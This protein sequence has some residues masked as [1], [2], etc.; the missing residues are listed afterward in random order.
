M[1]GSHMEC[2]PRITRD[3]HDRSRPAQLGMSAVSSNFWTVLLAGA[4]ELRIAPPR[5]REL[6]R[7]IAALQVR[8]R[9]G[10]ANK[11]GTRHGACSTRRARG[12]TPARP[13]P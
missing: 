12:T 9:K 5:A 4:A 10:A 6:A 11:E 8:N 1:W 2:A 13:R 7:A 3:A